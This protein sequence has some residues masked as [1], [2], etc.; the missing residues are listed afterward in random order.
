VPLPF[1]RRS[2]CPRCAASLR[3]CRQCRFYERGAGKDCREPQADEVVDKEQ[4][5]FCDYFQPRAGLTA[6]RDAAA[7]A[8]RAKLAAA[9]GGAAPPP[10][11]SAAP[12]APSQAQTE[13]DEARRKLEALFGKPKE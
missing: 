11:P 4:S 8:A 6:G 2:E 9:F 7:E 12:A 13:A 5:N 3:C 10:K 1:G